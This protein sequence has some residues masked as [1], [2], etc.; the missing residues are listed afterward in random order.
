MRDRIIPP[1]LQDQEHRSECGAVCP[2]GC[3][4]WCSLAE[5]PP[6]TSLLSN[7]L[8]FTFSVGVRL[9]RLAGAGCGHGLEISSLITVSA[10]T[11]VVCGGES[12]R[13]VSV[14]CSSNPVLSEEGR[15]RRLARDM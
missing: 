7:G 3:V 11:C 13:C 15:G 14:L 4:C 9:A 12:V 8:R 1:Q 10:V 5:A 6:V 2:P